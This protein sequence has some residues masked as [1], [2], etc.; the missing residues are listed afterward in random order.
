MSIVSGT[1]GAYESSGA[2]RDASDKNYRANQ[3][4]NLMNMLLTLYERGVD[5]SKINFPK[6]LGIPEG[7]LKQGNV[8]LPGYAGDSE[9]ALYDQARGQ[10]EAIS[11]ISGSP[12]DQAAAFQKIIDQYG[13]GFAKNDQFVSDLVS[14]KLTDQ[15]LS[16]AQPV[17]EA[18]TAAAKARKSAGL[19]AL[20]ETLNNID[21]IQ[22][23]KGYTGDSFGANLLKFG[24]RRSINTSGANDTAM[25][26]L[27]NA[28]EKAGI[29]QS[30]RNTRLANIDLPNR[31]MSSALTRRGLPSKLVAENFDTALSPFRFFK[32]A[33]SD[34]K[35]FNA[36]P[37]D[38]PNAGLGQILAAGASST[39][40]TALN[41]YLQKRLRDQMAVGG[42]GSAADWKSQGGNLAKGASW[43]TI[44]DEAWSPSAAAYYSEFGM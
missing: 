16:E 11:G 20:Q 41:Y 9:R 30:G 15:S 5:L 12:Q 8:L 27:E 31:V 43:N 35:P 21:T 2:Q 6:A 22:A 17:F 32:T 36:P 4:N 39:G 3:Q 29:Q 19:E 26:E 7:L 1:I 38:S 33:G 40:N 34:F 18:R 28:M 13:P 44:P 42:A 24:A 25:A 10:S 37:L 23:R 14:G